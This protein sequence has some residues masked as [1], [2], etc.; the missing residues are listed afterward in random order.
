VFEPLNIPDVVIYRPRRFEDPRGY[1]AETYNART[2]AE[3]GI[4]A[5]FVQDNQSL[6]RPAGT[7]R[8]LHYQIAPHAQG[9]LVRVLRGSVFDVAVDIR[10]G[11]P[12]FGRFASATLTAAGGEQI[13]VPAGFA[14]GFCTLEPDT[15]VAY[16]VTALYA[17]ECDRGIAWDDVDLAIP[18]PVDCDAAMLSDK[19]RR[20]PRLAE[21]ADVF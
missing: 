17:P 13:W 3:N 14:H 4:D 2:F 21:T 11:S 9:K 1:F 18:W 8:G 15:E 12:H 20:H 6:S 7:I 16:K 5:V 10:R 19:D